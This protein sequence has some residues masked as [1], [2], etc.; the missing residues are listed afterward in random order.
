MGDATSIRLKLLGGWELTSDGES[1]PIGTRQQR[2]VA[3]LAIYGRRARSFYSGLLWP[4]CP[5]ARA[6]G[7]LRAA[8]FTV[9][10]RL[11]GLLLIRGHD[12]CLETTVDVD[13]HRL[14]ATLAAICSAQA[15][16]TDAWFASTSNADLLPGWYDD[17]LVAEQV[18]LRELYLNAAERLAERSL[19]ERDH[20]Q[21]VHLA[22]AVLDLDPLRESAVRILMRAHLEMGNHGAA[23][24]IFQRFA[25]VTAS[26][27]GMEPSPQVQHLMTVVRQP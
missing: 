3:A 10:R 23:L 18:R 6:M 27:L 17:W 19:R 7:S 9:T 24:K 22:Q 5:D 21:A 13:L 14:N 20:Y 25:A 12:L 15:V 4:D 26:E 2:L 11:P 16:T 8:V 1:L